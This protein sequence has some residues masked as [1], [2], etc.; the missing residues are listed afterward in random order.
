MGFLLFLKLV[1]GIPVF[2]ILV[3]TLAICIS[4]FQEGTSE[5]LV[6]VLLGNKS[7][8]PEDDNGKAVKMKDGSRLADVCTCIGHV[9]QITTSVL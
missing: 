5:E 2:K 1:S 6:S 9:V 4:C 7:D 3:R 8:L